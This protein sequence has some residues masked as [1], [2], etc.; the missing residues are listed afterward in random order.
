MPKGSKIFLPCRSLG[1]VSN[2]IPLQVRYI[3]SRKENLIVTCVGKSFHTYGI[4]H[5]GLLSVGGLHPEDITA[6]T[7]DAFHVYTACNN[8]IYA[9]RRGTELKHVYRGHKKPVHL[10]MPFGAHL[11]SIDEA[12]SVKLWDIKDESVFLELTFSN[13]TFH[14]TTI[15]HP[16]T[17][18]N[19]I[20]LG[21]EQGEMQLWNVNNLKM[22]Y[23]FKGWNSP[24]TCLEQAPA[25]D[26]VAVGLACGKI[27]L[28]NLKF[29]ETI[30]EFMQDWGVVT[31]ISFR[32]DG[33]PIM[34]TGSVIGHIVFWDLEERRVASQLLSA[35]DGSVTGMICLPSEPLILTSSPDN[36]LKL[37]IFDRSDGGARLLRIREGHSAPPSHL[38]FHGA[39]GH[40]ILSCAGDST[41]RIFNTQTEQ[42]NKSLGKASYNRKASKK[43]G[44][45]AEDPLIMPPITQFTSEITREKEWDNIA[46]VHLG[47]PMVT[48]WSYDKV[49]MGE[50]KLLPERFH[51]K[52]LVSSGFHDVAA[53]CL[54]LTHCG[55]FVLVGYSTGHIDRFNMQSGIWRD[56]YGAPKAHDASVR[57]VTTDPLNQMT[58]SGSSDCKIKFWKFKNKGANPLTV[59][60]LDEPISFFRSH[61]ESSMLAVAL[62]DFDVYVVDID[63]RRIVRKFVGHTAQITDAT[64]S[65]D[66][67][68]L[69]TSSM[70]CSIRT[71]DIPSCH[72]VDEFSTEVACVS[73]DISPTGEVLATAHVDYLGIFLWTNRTLYSK[74]SLKALT[75]SVQPPL[76]AFPE[77]LTEHHEEKSEVEESDD[78][79]FISPEQISN[80]LVTLSG[81]A[82]SR[83]QNLLNLDVIKKRNKPKSPP[84]APKA[85]PFFLPTVSS[86]TFQF[87]LSKPESESSKILTPS[88]LLNLTEF[89]KLLDKTRQDDDFSH[90]I[91]KLKSF[92]PSMIDFEIKSLA[93]EGGGSVEVMLQFLKSVEF[94]LKSNKDFEL[95]EAYLGVFLKSHGTVVAAEETLRNYLTNIQSCHNVVWN[96]LQ[97][98]LLYNICVVQNLKMM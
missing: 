67:R 63:T 43:R 23:S 83:W 18:I 14:I 77:C 42:F 96:R 6:M 74:V 41:L 55:N 93:P 15:C 80:D 2:H 82:A 90:V 3:K 92:G 17:Y 13:K 1:Y 44:R 12:S 52:K 76:V 25:I 78:L 59:L 19:K 27:K 49:K 33:S 95:A 69:V 58:I 61:S 57:G 51:K 46:A 68:W 88:T 29:D 10:M 30:M 48:T 39:N 50:L 79:E 38:R 71:W 31:S 73:L 40:N 20:L 8:E 4:T 75:P 37:W 53:T 87:D 62:E 26:V 36:T 65:P 16:S 11:I 7:A 94:M 45:T 32:T 35:H 28:H 24:I 34:A 89:G 64:F 22:I 85:A 21:S 47:I 81:F 91:E 9:W 72:L 60:T 70:D 54:C 86:L 98:K 56:S 97:D 84:K 66:S 5:F